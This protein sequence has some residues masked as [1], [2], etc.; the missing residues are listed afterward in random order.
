M[1]AEAGRHHSSGEAD[2]VFTRYRPRIVVKFRDDVE[3][4]YVDGVEEVIE[5]RHL[6]S[7]STLGEAFPGISLTRFYTA[8][9]PGEIQALVDR[10]TAMDRTYSPPNL[11]TYFVIDCPPGIDSDALTGAISRWET[12]EAAYVESRPVLP[13][14]CV[15][16]D[17]PRIAWQGYL[18]KAPDGIDAEYAWQLPNGCGK[19]IKFI[20]VEGGWMLDHEDL[21]AANIALI[22]GVNTKGVKTIDHGTAVLGIVVGVDNSVGG[23]GIAP[24]AAARVSSIYTSGTGVSKSDAILKAISEATFGDVI[25]LELQTAA[26]CPIETELGIFDTIRLGTALGIVIVEAAGNANSDLDAFKDLAGKQTLNRSDSDFKESG[27]IMVAAAKPSPV[28]HEP[29]KA[30]PGDGTNTGSRIDCYAWGGSIDTSWCDGQGTKSL[31]TQTFGGT[32][33]ASAIIAGAAL[34]IQGAAEATLKYRFSGWQLRAIMSDPAN[35]TSPASPMIGSYGLGIMPD[36]K[37]ILSSSTLSAVPDVYVR[38]YV[39]DTGDPHTGAISASPD[40]ILRTA[41]MA[42]PQGSLGQGSNTEDSNTLG[43]EAQAGQDNFIYVRVRN[44]GGV[45][46]ANVGVTV[47]WSPVSTLVIPALWTRVDPTKGSGSPDV[48]LANVPAGNQLTVS[49]PITWKAGNIPSPGHYCF[50]AL[51]DNELDPAPAPP[52]FLDW[53][54]FRRLIKENNNVTWR[55]FNVVSSQPKPPV[56]P[57]PLHNLEVVPLPFLVPG[58][59]QTP[60]MFRLEVVARLPEGALIWVEAPDY[61]VDAMR[62]NSRHVVGGAARGVSWIRLNPHGRTSVGE[63]VFPSGSVTALR[64]LV[65]IPE[66][67]RDGEYEVYASQLHRDPEDEQGGFDEVGRVTWLLLPDRRTR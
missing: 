57:A 44:R 59:P 1:D 38:D 28:P 19:G 52:D 11:L 62:G 22:H 27:A 40:V 33:G 2:S 20:D 39:G 46:A 61:F 8:L 51:V 25:L 64:L 3:L 48:T 14:P 31:Y 49:D 12:V 17:D 21:T 56:P 34:V 63:A 24:H 53:D 37:K 58:A 16:P 65:H 9:E 4:P 10:A 18:K 55:N 26:Y 67:W 6:E 41:T 45:A 42:D 50:I 35:G 36:L 7:W 43:Q 13:A 15:T 23:L 5:G 47:Y 32:S 66:K 30:P 54:N 60:E 29:V